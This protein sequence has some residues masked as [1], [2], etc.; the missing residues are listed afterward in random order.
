TG[1]HEPSTQDARPQRPSLTGPASS[2]RGGLEGWPMTHVT[3]SGVIGQI[4]RH[5]GRMGYEDGFVDQ[6]PDIDPEETT[7]WLDSLDAV[8]AARGDA[9]AEFLVQKMLGRSHQVG[10]DVSG[11]VATPYVNSIPISAE[12]ANYWFPG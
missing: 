5:D 8:R 7:E 9:R 6:L 11:L 1:S 2:L 12:K 3:R 4:A 10:L